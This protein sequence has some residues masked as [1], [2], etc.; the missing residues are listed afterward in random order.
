V[1]AG[2]GEEVP[3]ALL[4]PGVA[5]DGEPVDLGGDRFGF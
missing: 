3:H 1:R 2:G 5:R 4:R